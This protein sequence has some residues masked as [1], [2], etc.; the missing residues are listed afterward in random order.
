MEKEQKTLFDYYK[1]FKVSHIVPKL[2]EE[3]SKE[4]VRK[5]SWLNDKK[6]SVYN[7]SIQKKI[8]R[9]IDT[10]KNIDIDLGI[11]KLF[12]DIITDFKTYISRS[13]NFETFG[14]W[15]WYE[16]DHI[17]E[18]LLPSGSL[19]N[20][21]V[22]ELIEEKTGKS[23][24]D[25][26]D[27]ERWKF[28]TFV[29]NS[30]IPSIIWEDYLNIFNNSTIYIYYPWTKF[31]K[32]WKFREV[33]L[34][35]IVGNDC[36]YLKDVN[37]KEVLF[38]TQASYTNNKWKVALSKDILKTQLDWIVKGRIKYTER[39]LNQ[40]EKEINQLEEKLQDKK[41]KLEEYISDFAFEEEKTNKILEDG[42]TI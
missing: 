9:Y 33:K 17:T 12:P 13:T 8:K 37:T 34:Y 25:L 16:S 14:Y 32:K 40:T 2:S 10:R 29:N 6:L 26:N 1:K 35:K 28:E 20:C 42:K 18:L 39:R 31:N 19:S 27:E 4:L 3:E 15:N 41:V 24:Y 36:I 7:D 5:I 38:F 21:I 22:T 11:D 23:I 30:S